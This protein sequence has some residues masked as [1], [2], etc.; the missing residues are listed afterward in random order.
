M[1]RKTLFPSPQSFIELLDIY[2]F[3]SFST[4]LSND[5]RAMD[6]YAIDITYLK[7]KTTREQPNRV[8]GIP[9]KPIP[10][11]NRDIHLNINLS[12]DIFY[13]QGIVFLRT[14]SRNMQSCT[15]GHVKIRYKISMVLGLRRTIV[16][17]RVKDSESLT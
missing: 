16:C 9:T 14:I 17:T 7:Y 2:Y 3:T 15:A 5:R 10:Q 13:V 8:S 4:T 12:A 6:I 11:T 1:Y